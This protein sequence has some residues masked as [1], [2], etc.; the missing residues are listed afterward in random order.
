MRRVHRGRLLAL[1]IAYAIAACAAPAR[2][3]TTGI[4]FAPA[5][6][7]GKVVWNDLV[8]EDIEAAR[9][10]YGE[11]FGWT[12]ETTTLAA[13]RGYVIARAGDAF[14][15]GLVPVDRPSDGSR[16]SRW[17]PYFSVA[18]VDATVATAT[19]S[20]G[21][22]VVEPRNVPLG[23]VAALIDA[24]GAVIG[25]AR[26]RVGDPDD[27]TTAPR[28][29]RVVFTE[30][31]ANDPAS[32]A[33]F[34]EAVVGL[35]ARTVR[36]RGGEYTVLSGGGI[37]RAGVLKNPTPDWAPLWLTAFGVADVRSATA[38]A[39]ALGGRILLPVSPDVREGT[40]AIVS[41]PAG[42]I[43]VLQQWPTAP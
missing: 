24:E 15:A 40:V 37:D 22:V 39:Q 17:L 13:T 7:I 31:I 29:H 19:A 26:S 30:L 35:V 36:R 3:D 27:A 6:L 4:T 9:R 33:R 11:L 2:L 42:A 41:D 43:L 20:G 38:R 28:I 34:Y 16:V 23:R 1:A 18:D 8:T 25:V 10:F 32:A 21:R 14:V 12:F 5:P